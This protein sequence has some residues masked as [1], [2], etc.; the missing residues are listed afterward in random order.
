L[1]ERKNYIDA[2]KGLSMLCIV[3]G[4]F[5]MEVVNKFVFTFHVPIFLIVSGL[6][7]TPRDGII[8]KRVTQLVK[9]YLTTAVIVYIIV[10]VK[11]TAKFILG[12]NTTFVIA[13]YLSGFVLEVLYG[14]GSRTDFLSFE[15]PAIGAVWF[16]LAI[17]WATAI[18]YCTEKYIPDKLSIVKYVVI[19]AVFFASY[20]SAKYTWLPL[21]VQAGMSSALFMYIGYTAKK[22]RVLEQPS[23][24]IWFVISALIWVAAIYFSYKNDNMSVVRSYFPDVVINICG[25]VASSYI[26]IIIMKKSESFGWLSNSAPY[27]LLCCWGKNSSIIL[28]CH[29]IELRTVN[30]SF[31]YNYGKIGILAVFII[32]VTLISLIS[33][34]IV[35]HD[36]IRRFF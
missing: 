21:S 15:L 9:P 14:S 3:A 7:F 34:F 22:Y 20:F 16:F 33:W 17:V 13:T 2:V 1:A 31:L 26:I 28:C 23:K 19:I 6:F 36:K 8:K 18:L 25:A 32:K 5:G 12:R 11:E 27:H 4:H 29:L 10:I 30:W 35:K 24:I